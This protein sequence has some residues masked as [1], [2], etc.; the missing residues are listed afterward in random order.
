MTDDELTECIASA[1]TGRGLVLVPEDTLLAV[2]DFAALRDLIVDGIEPF[3]IAGDLQIPH[4]ELTLTP[5]QTHEL[6]VSLPWQKRIAAA[7]RDIERVLEET[8]R[9]GGQFRFNVWISGPE[10][11]PPS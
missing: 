3:R 11:W 5:L 1:R 4:V 2:C 6:H 7:R 9:I 10:D 8:H